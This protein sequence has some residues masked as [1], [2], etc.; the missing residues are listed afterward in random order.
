VLARRGYEPAVKGTNGFLC[1]VHRQWQASFSD[2]DFWNPDVRSP[3]CF[4][5]QAARSVVPIN[6]RRT[7]L[8]LAGVSIPLP[9]RTGGPTCRNRP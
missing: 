5:P 2:E 7:E 4:N 6:L 8:A 1:L 9:A 3:V